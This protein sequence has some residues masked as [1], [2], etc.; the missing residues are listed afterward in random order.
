MCGQRVSCLIPTYNEG[1]R[2]GGVLAAVEGHPLV[3]EVI[4]IDD[5]STD[6]TSERLAHLS[7][8]TL[9]SLPRNRGKSHAVMEGVRRANHDLIMT[10]DA[11]LVGLTAN[12]LT[13]LIRPVVDGEADITVSLR[14]NALAIYK[15]FGLDFVSGE[16][17]F[18]RSL[19]N[20][21]EDVGRLRGFELEAF[22]NEGVMREA[23]RL[24]IV[25]W[26]SVVGVRKSAKFGMWAGSVRD[27]KMA[28]EILRF[29][30]LTRKAT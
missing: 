4:V 20:Q 26:K 3:G 10:L 21:L 16:R 15:L 19:F 14:A 1:T 13:A 30:R 5:A 29:L 27:A 28:W 7:G 25:P 18:H 9:L 8:I 24:K 11:D 23:L 2:I 6:G 22:M 12:D 17:V